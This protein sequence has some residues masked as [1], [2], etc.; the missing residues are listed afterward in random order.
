MILPVITTMKEMK[1]KNRI[2]TN[3]RV[4]SI[5]KGMTGDIYYNTREVRIRIIMKEVLGC[6]QSMLG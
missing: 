1:E 4:G 2:K 6:V 3:I 5:V